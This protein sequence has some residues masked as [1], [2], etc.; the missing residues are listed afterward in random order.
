[1]INNRIVYC[2]GYFLI[3]VIVGSHS[4]LF[5]VYFSKILLI[6][7]F[8][9][10]IFYG[11]QH[12]G[13]KYLK[14]SLCF[15][16]LFAI[17]Q[18]IDINILHTEYLSLKRFSVHLFGNFGLGFPEPALGSYAPGVF[19]GLQH[20]VRVSG[21][22]DEPSHFISILLATIPLVWSDKRIRIPVVAG[23]FA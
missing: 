3:A 18:F 4:Q 12:Y 17:E 9:F 19:K 21:S 15:S 7:A 16:I 11:M 5:L 14:I 2:L 1:F 13:T 10:Y 6:S 22:A 23:L 8:V 20:L